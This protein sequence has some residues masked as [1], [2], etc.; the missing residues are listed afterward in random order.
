MASTLIV[1]CGND[2][3]GISPNAIDVSGISV[4]SSI[5]ITNGSL[6]Q[7]QG[8]GLKTTDIVELINKDE[9]TLKFN[10]PVSSVQE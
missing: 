2:D 9:A 6:L 4:P 8:S 3:M 1:S 10:A 7:L 5:T